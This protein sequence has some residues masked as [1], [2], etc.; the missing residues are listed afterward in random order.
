[1]SEVLESNINTLT[2]VGKEWLVRNKDAI[3][4][5]RRKPRR[6][7]LEQLRLQWQLSDYQLYIRLHN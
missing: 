1:M 2:D 7:S 6:R 3:E 5:K 4:S